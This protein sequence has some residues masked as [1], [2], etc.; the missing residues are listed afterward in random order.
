LIL[1][2][3]P[4]RFVELLGNKACCSRPLLQFF[5]PARRVTRLWLPA[6]ISRVQFPDNRPAKEI[7]GH[8]LAAGC[9]A[10][11]AEIDGLVTD[12]AEM[13][14]QLKAMPAAISFGK[15][16]GRADSLPTTAKVAALFSIGRSGDHGRHQMAGSF[17][18][19]SS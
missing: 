14:G 2:Q 19:L 7:K 12:V 3:T 11:F 4:G 6:H 16:K 1:P 5:Q 15:L 13:K 10:A 18:S 17:G 9:R 8:S